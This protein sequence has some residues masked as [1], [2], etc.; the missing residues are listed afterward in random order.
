M[1]DEI[2]K[3]GNTPKYGKFALGCIWD[4]SSCPGEVQTQ[5]RKV[6]SFPKGFQCKYKKRGYRQMQL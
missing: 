3:K 5:N 4:C 2:V 1:G 6:S